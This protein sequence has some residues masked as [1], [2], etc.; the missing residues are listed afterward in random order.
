[1]ISF[2]GAH[3]KG[4][5]V[6]LWCEKKEK[7]QNTKKARCLFIAALAG[8]RICICCS[9]AQWYHLRVVLLSTENWE[10]WSCFLEQKRGEEASSAPAAAFLSEWSFCSE[11]NSSHLRGIC[12]HAVAGFDSTGFHKLGWFVSCVSFSHSPP[13][14]R[15]EFQKGALWPYA[16]R[17]W[18]LSRCFPCVSTVL[19]VNQ[20]QA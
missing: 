5:R 15:H 16:V 3:Q 12:Q 10:M 2:Y 9:Q 17:S 20:K 6:F 13:E 1:M 7:P 11:Q 4:W 14:Y 19:V 18:E 8:C